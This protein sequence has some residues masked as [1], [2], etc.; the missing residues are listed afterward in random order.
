MTPKQ[1]KQ[2]AINIARNGSWIRKLKKRQP[3]RPLY[4][5]KKS[6]WWSGMEIDELGGVQRRYV[7]A[8]NGRASYIKEVH[9]RPR[10]AFYI[11]AY[12]WG[13]SHGTGMPVAMVVDLETGKVRCCRTPAEPALHEIK[14]VMINKLL[15]ACKGARPGLIE[16]L[17]TH[18]CNLKWR[19]R[20]E[21]AR[22]RRELAAPVVP[23]GIGDGSGPATTEE[24][25]TSPFIMVPSA[26][27]P[28]PQESVLF[29]SEGGFRIA[30][31]T[32]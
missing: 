12:R 10:V 22:Q 17:I 23:Y 15:K 28:G 32:N 6:I 14:Q 21:L 13:G 26:I 29:D 24:Y 11:G 3:G 19:E 31:S 2:R 27:V 9:L 25:G 18:L 8:S 5:V 20:E 4:I 1:A 7:P 30:P 16:Q